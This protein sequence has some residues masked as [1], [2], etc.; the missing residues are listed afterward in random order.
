MCGRLRLERLDLHIGHLVPVKT[1][2]GREIQAI[3]NGHAREE[4]IESWYRNGW[5]DGSMHVDQYTEGRPGISF[6]VPPGSAI[7]CIVR[8][9]E[10]K[11]ELIWVANIVTRASTSAEQQVHPRFPRL[12]S[13]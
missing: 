9:V 2:S 10:A 5:Q 13:Y 6:S 7:K 3:W 12:I 11:N 4:S 8:Q 1:A